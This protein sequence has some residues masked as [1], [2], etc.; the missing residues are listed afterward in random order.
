MSDRFSEGDIVV[1]KAD[2]ANSQTSDK[3]DYSAWGRTRMKVTGGDEFMVTVQAID[4]RPDRE[5][6]LASARPGYY[7]DNDP[8]DVQMCFPVG[9]LQLAP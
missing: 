5:W 2:H 6:L 4:Q 1:V 7:D 8:Q 3:Y 9:H